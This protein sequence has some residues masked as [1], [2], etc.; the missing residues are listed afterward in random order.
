L[1]HAV[2]RTSS[3]SFAMTPT[4]MPD[5]ASSVVVRASSKGRFFVDCLS[6]HRPACGVTSRFRSCLRAQ[7]TRR[8][9]RGKR[10]GSS[11][12]LGLRH[13]ADVEGPADLELTTRSPP[14]AF[15]RRPGAGNVLERSL[16][17]GLG[18]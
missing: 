14:A 8:A 15:R 10:R 18:E 13:L 1:P 9:A 6:F 7:E 16:V 2:H 11:V 3:G 4:E 12:D 17:N 5:Q